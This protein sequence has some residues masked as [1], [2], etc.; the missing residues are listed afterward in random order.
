MTRFKEQKRSDRAIDHKNV[1][2]LLWAKQFCQNR[3]EISAMK[4][5][6][7]R[8]YQQLSLIEKALNKVTGE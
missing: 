6:T 2:E 3:L 1:E 4:S 5:H 8:W 7:K